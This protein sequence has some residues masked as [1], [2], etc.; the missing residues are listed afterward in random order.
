MRN[1]DHLIEAIDS[2]SRP[3]EWVVIDEV[4]KT[5]KFL[6]VVHH[7]IE[8]KKIKL[9]LTGSSARKLK[10]GAANL[11]VGRAFSFELFPLT[12]IELAG[13]VELDKYLSTG[14]CLHLKGYA[15]KQI[16]IT[17]S[18]PISRHI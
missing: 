12:H 9:A 18:N 16:S 17:I 11:L 15:G 6:D 7:L 3:P 1:P 5:P 2:Q 13:R 4:Q 10:R 14:D 8:N